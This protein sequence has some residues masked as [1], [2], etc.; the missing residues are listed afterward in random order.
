M[1]K[2]KLW[3][4]LIGLFSLERAGWA[5]TDASPYNPSGGEMI[6]VLLLTAIVFGFWVAYEWV[7]RSRPA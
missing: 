3:G 2:R 7:R 4:S 5:Q 6:F 1:S